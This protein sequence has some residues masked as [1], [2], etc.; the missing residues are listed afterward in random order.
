MNQYE[1]P[2]VI[3]CLNGGCILKSPKG[4]HTNGTCNCIS[5]VMTQSQVVHTKATIQYLRKLLQERDLEIQLL[6]KGKTREE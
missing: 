5:R 1:H 2:S 4:M 6:K 3:G